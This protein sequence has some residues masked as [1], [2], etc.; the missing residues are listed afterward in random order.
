[1]LT[2]R[3]R[4]LVEFIDLETQRTGGVCPSFDEMA[5]AMG[6]KHKSGVH[7][8][9]DECEVRGAVKRH[10]H[11]CRAIEVI[12]LKPRVKWF[13][14]DAEEKVLKPMRTTP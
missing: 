10:K 7:R 5:K 11:R 4:Q 8:L 9:L 2:H 14:F 3:Q 12:R 6:L 1:M 13:R